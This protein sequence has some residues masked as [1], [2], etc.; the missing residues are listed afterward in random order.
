M[1][2]EQLTGTDPGSPTERF[3]L[4]R[5]RNLANRY[6]VRELLGCGGMGEVWLAYDLKLRIEVALKAMLP[7]KFPGEKGREILRREVRN[8]REVISPNVCRVF[9]LFEAEGAELVSMEYVKGMTL[10]QILEERGPLELREAQEIASQFLAGLQE[11][12]RAGLAHGDVKPSN[13]M[14]TRTGRVVVMDFGLARAVEDVP[15]KI[16]GTPAY[17]APEQLAGGSVNARTDVFSAGVVLAE[18]I[19]PDGVGSERSRR[20]LW[21]TVRTDPTDLPK[22]TWSAVLWEALARD[23]EARF[24]SAG[25]LLRALEEVTLRIARAEHGNPY[26]G[27]A[28][29]TENDTE[30]FFGREAEVEQLWRKLDRP[31]LHALIGPSGAGKSSF[32]RAGVMATAPA[33]WRTILATPGSRPFA[34]LA[35]ALVEQMRSDPDAGDQL[36]A[37]EEPDLGIPVLHHWRRRHPHVLIIID[38]FE[39]LFTLNPAETQERFAALLSRLVLEADMHVLL[40]LRDDFLFHCH[41]LEALNP[42]F[43][44]LTVLGPPTGV[45]LRRALVQPALRCGYHFEDESLVDQI[46]AEVEGERGALPL[47]AFAVSQLWLRRDRER[48]LLIR[49][50]YEEIGGVAGALAQHAEITIERIGSDQISI[51]REVLRNLVTAQGTRVSRDRS[52]LLSVFPWQDREKAAKVLDSLVA[53]RLLTSYEVFDG[54][55]DQPA[56]QRVEIVHES[57]LTKWPRL[58]RWQ[59]QDAEGAQ[60]RDDLRQAAHLWDH[61]DRAEDFLWTGTAYQEYQLWRERYRGALTPLE[62]SFV[63]AATKLAGRKRTRRRMAVSSIVALALAIAVVTSLLW[64]KAEKDARR[65][66]AAGLLSLGRLKLDDN[67]T[68]ALAYA[69]ASLERL[70]SAAARRFALEVLWRGGAA[71]VIPVELQS[72]DFSADGRWLATGG[73]TGGVQLWSRDGGPPKV[74]EKGNGRL[75][76]VQFGPASDRL[77]LKSGDRTVRTLSVPDM[78]ELR[79]VDFNSTF[80]SYPAGPESS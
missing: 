17:M 62:E 73:A 2:P 37:L 26:P 43:S 27:L 33:G 16:S 78:R 30:Y 58:V 20:A 45:G 3:F 57:L 41:R 67:P 32:L 28:A 1:D 34:S 50:A 11:I 42:A 63:E 49:Q 51:V 38:Q 5:G 19:N 47:M 8:A 6:E 68:A 29:F 54:S 64:R 77:L 48:G 61:H 52:E 36:L 15:A 44:D 35:E 9:D 7:E 10:Q 79:K 53:A 13:I 46:L 31:R 74:V 55:A 72:V 80:G 40:S 12:H 60:L 23:A 66:E 56:R 75:Q 71:L 14:V 76:E 22:T 70:N 39:E 65:A 59:T 24:A 4:S 21:D 18:M 25:E 69:L